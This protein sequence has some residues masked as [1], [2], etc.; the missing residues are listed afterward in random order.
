MTKRLALRKSVGYLVLIAMLLVI[1][2]PFY[3]MI[4]TSFKTNGEIS[5]FPPTYFPQNP[6]LLQYQQA[7]YQ[8]GFGVYFRNS[9]IVSLISTFF[10]MILAALA[11]YALARLPIRG[12]APIMVVLLMIS[13]FPQVGVIFPL[14]VLFQSIGWLNSYQ[15]LIV[16]YTAFNLP[17]AIWVMRTYFVGIPKELDEAARVDG[18][19]VMTTVFRVILPLATPGLFTGAIFTFVACWTEFFFALVFNN[20]NAFRTIP[21]GIALFGG[22]FTIPYGTMFAA[23]TV[24]VLPVVLLVLIFQRWVVAGLTAGAVKG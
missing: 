6:T 19:S 2:A 1:V 24:A 9:L 17:F 16:P 13:T 7:F 22:Q 8:F 10:V 23:S 14:F 4:I 5:A 20:S 21:V 18:A 3:W 11:S 15:A 12:K